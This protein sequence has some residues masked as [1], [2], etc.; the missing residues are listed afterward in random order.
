MFEE[1]LHV[2]KHWKQRHER[3]RITDAKLLKCKFKS[4]IILVIQ[5]PWNR[6]LNEQSGWYDVTQCCGRNGKLTTWRMVFYWKMHTLN[7]IDNRIFVSNSQILLLNRFLPWGA[8]LSWATLVS[9]VQKTF[10]N[11]PFA[12]DIL[13]LVRTL[14]PHQLY[15]LLLIRNK[16]AFSSKWKNIFSF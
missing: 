14:N 12:I 15:F 7:E 6:D 1:S 10:K 4:H 3:T 11:H 8:N 5:H 2:N 9:K 13:Q 16:I